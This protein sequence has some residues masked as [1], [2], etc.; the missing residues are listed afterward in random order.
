MLLL[1]SFLVH[2]LSKKKKKKDS[3]GCTVWGRWSRRFVQKYRSFMLP[4]GTR[5]VQADSGSDSDSESRNLNLPA[6]YAYLMSAGGGSRH[7]RNF[8]IY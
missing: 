4:M 8:G 3:G 6:L 5:I 7:L 1:T 2:V